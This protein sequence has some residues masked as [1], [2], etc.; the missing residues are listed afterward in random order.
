TAKDICNMHKVWLEEIYEWAGRYRKVNVSRG[1]FHFAAA[2]QIPK[3][4]AELEKGPLRKLTP[5][6]FESLEE[7][8][9]ALSVVHTELVLIH[10]FR[11][12]N[13]RVARMLSILM[14]LQVGLPPLDFSWIVA[15]K[16]KEYIEAVQMGMSHNYA[17]MEKIF[18]AVIRKTLR[19]RE[20]K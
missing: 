17:P 19:T 20:Q 2:E 18:R 8:I 12:G 13:G 7:V 15:K 1:D 11:E 4:M 5:C 9:K 16:K 6:R 14:A 10:P 3:L